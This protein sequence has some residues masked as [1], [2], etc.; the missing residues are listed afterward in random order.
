MAMS[1]RQMTQSEVIM[2]EIKKNSSNRSNRK[3][4]L[5]VVEKYQI[6]VQH[7]SDVVIVTYWWE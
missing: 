6:D 2:P 4:G 7:N 3:G 1:R 5:T